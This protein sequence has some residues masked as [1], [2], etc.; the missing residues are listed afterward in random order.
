MRTEN[1]YS[2]LEYK[3]ILDW[4]KQSSSVLDLGCGDGELISLLVQEKQ[5]H[6]QGIEIDEQAIHAC[7]AQG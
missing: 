1:P 2:K 6:V 3:I 5:V 7:V 4:I